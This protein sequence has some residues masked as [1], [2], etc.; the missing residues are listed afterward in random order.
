MK[1]FAFIAVL[2]IASPAYAHEQADPAH[3]HVH[4]IPAAIEKNLV[5]ITQDGA[6]RYITANGIPNHKTGQ[7]PNAGNPNSISPQNY[8]YRVPLHPQNSGHS[9][10]KN[11]VIGVALN[12]IPFD[13]ATAECYG[14]ARGQR[15]PMESCEWREEAI[16]NGHGKLGLDT[17]N[18]HVQPNGAYHY[19]G[20]PYGLLDILGGDDVVQ[21]GYA[22]DGFKLMV[23][24]SG[25]YKSSY[26][27][28][29]G[30]RP[31]GP[32]GKYDGTYTADYEYDAAA[33]NLDQCNG[34]MLG[35]EYVY[36]VT[37]DFPFAP[38]CLMG[39]ADASFAFHRGPPPGGMMG[40][41]PPPGLHPPF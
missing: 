36:F 22:A 27:L 13:P 38:R 1:V 5:E 9:S 17:S 41:P 33:G 19:H 11:G 6:Y 16:V 23:S 18:A 24:R 3:P 20:V 34:T 14:R 39:R 25:A 4:T 28:K 12:G 32:G 21:V 29:K 15:G 26:R 8:H 7:F 35:G 37:K 40:R 2:L 10:P 31:D 30:I